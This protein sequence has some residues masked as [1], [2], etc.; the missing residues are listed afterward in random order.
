MMKHM[1]LTHRF[2]IAK[3]IDQ[4]DARR[5]KRNK[6][7]DR[8]HI[9][10]ALGLGGIALAAG[11]GLGMVY[12]VHDRIQ[13]YPHLGDGIIPKTEEQRRLDALPKVYTGR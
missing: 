8:L 12:V 10:I 1:G 9:D 3:Q 5:N 2:L 11:I 4:E 13:K 7:M 6:R